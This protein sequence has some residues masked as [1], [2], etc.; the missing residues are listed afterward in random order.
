[1]NMYIPCSQFYIT[2]ASSFQS[3]NNTCVQN[4]PHCNAHASSWANKTINPHWWVIIPL[5]YCFFTSYIRCILHIDVFALK[6][7]QALLRREILCP[8]GQCSHSMNFTHQLL[9]WSSSV[10]A[11][12]LSC[13]FTPTSNTRHWQ[14]MSNS[15]SRTSAAVPVQIELHDGMECQ[16]HVASLFYGDC[17]RCWRQAAWD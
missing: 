5:Y 4:T 11:P 6:V 13:R 14:L 17:W 7:H 9:L 12:T 3:Q 16:R 15:L 10:A 2:F 1:M 8:C